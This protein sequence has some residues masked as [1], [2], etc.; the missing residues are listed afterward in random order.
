MKVIRS[1]VADE[2]KRLKGEAAVLWQNQLDMSFFWWLNGPFS[3]S[4]S[5]WRDMVTVPNISK[6]KWFKKLAKNNNSNR[7]PAQNDQS[8]TS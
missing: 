4:K 7:F 6:A 1:A 2:E 8:Q 3:N 5:C